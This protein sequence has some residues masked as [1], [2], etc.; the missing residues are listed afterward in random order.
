MKKT[1]NHNIAAK[2]KLR[3]YFLDKYHANGCRLVLDC[4]QGEGAIWKQIRKTHHVDRYWGLDQ[5][6]KPG[7]LKIDAARVLAQPGWTENIIDIDTYGSPWNIWDSML[8]NISRD[9]TVY[10]TI[11][12][13]ITG[14]V[15]SLSNSALKA[16]GL[17]SLS[18]LPRGFH[19][20]LGKI[21][22]SSCLTSVCKYGIL[23]IEAVEAESNNRNVRYI[24]VH[25]R[26]Q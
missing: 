11:G 23:L 6:R 22:V 14:T 12:Q 24:G 21:S 25:L 26:R 19:P 13:L 20:K 1:D 4:C 9:T 16:M 2:I 8:P 17:D 7:R 5:K 10:L 15:G 18:H 3:K